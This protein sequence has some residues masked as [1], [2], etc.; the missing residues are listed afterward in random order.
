LA[1]NCYTAGAQAVKI[2]HA[3]KHCRSWSADD[4]HASLGLKGPRAKKIAIKKRGRF[5]RAIA[6]LNYYHIETESGLCGCQVGLF[7]CEARASTIWNA[8]CDPELHSML[9]MIVCSPCP[10]KCSKKK[11]NRCRI[12]GWI[13]GS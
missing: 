8:W 6:R 3:W 13:N 11:S 2:R 4:Y 9:E 12:P 5:H 7:P 10:Y 1:P